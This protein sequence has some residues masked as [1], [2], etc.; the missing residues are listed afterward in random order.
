MV[1]NLPYCVANQTQSP[2]RLHA[3][4]TESFA[5]PPVGVHKTAEHVLH[6]TAV[7]ECEKIVVISLQVPHLTSKK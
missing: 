1:E 7:W 6:L 3:E 4:P 5:L 2:L